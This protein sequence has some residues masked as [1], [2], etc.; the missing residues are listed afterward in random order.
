MEVLVANN[1]TYTFPGQE[2]PIFQGL[3]LSLQKGEFVLL[4]GESG[5]G[6]ST[7][8]NCLNGVIPLIWEGTMEG[9]VW[10]DGL[11]T[12]SATLKAL[13]QKVGTL[14]QDVESQLTQLSVEDELIFGLE[15][16]AISR[17]EGEERLKKIIPLVGLPRESLLQD[18]SG[19]QKQRLALG[20]LLAML[21][22]VI[23]LDEPLANLDHFGA[24]EFL[25]FLKI[26][27]QEGK[28]VLM[29]EHRLDLAA[30]YVDRLL[31]MTDGRIAFDLRD[32]KQI[33]REEVKKRWAPSRLSVELEHDPGLSSSP[34]LDMQGLWANYGSHRV[35][36]NINMRLQPGERLALIGNNGC[37]KSTFLKV[38]AGIRKGLRSGYQKFEI[39][40]RP[41]SKANRPFYS[42]KMG[43]VMQNPHHQ[44]FMQNVFMEVA[45]N[46]KGR[47][48]ATDIL[49]LFGLERLASRHPLSLSQG[50]KRLLAVAASLSHQPKI[51]LLDE[52]TIGQDYT[53]LKKMIEVVNYLNRQ[54]GMAVIT[55]THDMQAAK[56]LADRALLFNSGKVE[57]LSIAD[58]PQGC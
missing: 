4:S 41:V 12:A 40:G 27:C 56:S 7:L 35:W 6:K 25:K 46:A 15:N 53:S 31:Y 14:W 42:S 17:E 11:N 52:P 38:V 22:Q 58:I 43:F 34:A 13:V 47:T 32:R 21:P 20:A 36:Q 24:H 29:V 57:I 23:L 55:A 54:W 2:A 18:L 19:G 45:L 50:Q 39:L 48:E 10:A 5:C 33:E 30:R 26:L 8:L 51:L 44:L 28:T 3:S 1:L 49:S 37:G 16:I 9:E